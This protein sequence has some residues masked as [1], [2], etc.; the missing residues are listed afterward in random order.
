MAIVIDLG[1][2]PRP[3][4]SIILPG[5]GIKGDALRAVT[6]DADGSLQLQ[7]PARLGDDARATLRLGADG[8]L[9]G[10]FEQGGHR[11]ALTLQRRGEAQVDAA[12]TPATLA[13][14]W[15][16]TWVGGYELGGYPREVTLTLAP[17]AAG[18]TATLLIV[19]RRRSEVPIDQVLLNG[20]LLQLV[21]SSTG[22]TLEGRLH[23][24]DGS[25]RGQ[26]QQGP[27]EADFVLRKQAAP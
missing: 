15:L 8:R 27:L 12:P 24:A 3:A 19:G 18:S 23:A 7:M 26:F 22:I 21:S 13:A 5:R 11:T 16:G 4:G 17:G 25:L 9:V 2:T 14:P 20:A 6:I 1:D 10:S